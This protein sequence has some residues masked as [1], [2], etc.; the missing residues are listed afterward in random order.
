MAANKQQAETDQSASCELH[1]VNDIC[2]VIGKKSRVTHWRWVRDGIIPGP[3]IQINGRN[4]YTSRQKAEVI[5][6]IDS[7][8]TET[9]GAS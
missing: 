1:S 8:R 4:Y 3:D 6:A 2:V 7:M 5:A 9:G